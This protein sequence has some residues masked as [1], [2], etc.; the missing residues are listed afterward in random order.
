[1]DWY[2]PS[3]WNHS[4]SLSIAS[5]RLL[6]CH[7]IEEA[8]PFTPLP[9]VIPKNRS[10]FSRQF[11]VQRSALVLHIFPPTSVGRW[12]RSQFPSCLLFKHLLKDDGIPGLIPSFCPTCIHQLATECPFSPKIAGHR[13]QFWL[14]DVW[15]GRWMDMENY[16][17][18]S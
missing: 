10:C 15:A 13:F 3:R 5:V 7:Q 14:G 17:Y 12:R 9:Q 18:E 6:S 2:F 11:I 1:V 8:S 4:E 16:L